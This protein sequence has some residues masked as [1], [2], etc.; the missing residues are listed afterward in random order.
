MTPRKL[1]AVALGCLLSMTGCGG[2]ETDAAES[3][4]DTGTAAVTLTCP[5]TPSTLKPPTDQNLA[6]IYHAVG[7]QIYDCKAPNGG[8]FAWTFREPRADLFNAK[9]DPVGIHFG[10]PTWQHA[11]GSAVVGAKKAEA[12]GKTSNDIALLLL[13]T[14]KVADSD[15]GKF[16]DVTWIQRLNTVG[17]V[18]PTTPCTAANA[19]AVAEVNYEADYFFYRANPSGAATNLVCGG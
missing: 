19:G 12:P 1:G 7:V 5:A 16:S 8:T 10:G 3:L 13:K 2:D 17:G 11:D 15:P 14:T 4:T 6:F 9:N 18:A